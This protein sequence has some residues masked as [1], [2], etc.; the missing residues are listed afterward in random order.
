MSP[1][2]HPL[3]RPEAPRPDPPPVRR[4]RWGVIAL[5]GLTG[6]AML[7]GG[8]A[9]GP[10]QPGSAATSLSPAD[11]P[12]GGAGPLPR[13]APSRVVIP[14]LRVSAPVVPLGL[15]A[16]GWIEA[17]P[18]GSPGLTGWYR[19]APTPGERGTAVVVGHV[20]DFSG[21]AVFYRLG[22]LK[23]GSTVRVARKD[24]RTAV[25][26]VYGVQVFD[27]KDF[28]AATVYGSRGRPEL[29]VLT[30]GGGYSA[31]AGYT[32]NVV[33]F[34]RLAKTVQDVPGDEGERDRAALPALRGA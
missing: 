29:R 5:I 28:P 26:E 12:P 19:D 32:G 1:P 14:D 20:D 17:P 13:S 15:D 9:D 33:V 25:F 18:P 24:G 16:D 8:L 34:A 31:G 3:G 21:P 27:K 30:C 23:K 10:P 4:P 22:S 11:R 2:G 6:I 7:R